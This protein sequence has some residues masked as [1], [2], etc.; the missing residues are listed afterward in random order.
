[1]PPTTR[2]SPEGLNDVGHASRLLPIDFIRGVAL[3]GILLYNIQTY[4]LFAFL[5]PEQV[6]ALS[7]DTP[8][9]YGP[10]QFLVHLF[11]KGQFYTIYSFLFGLGFY[12]IMQKTQVAGQPSA[13]LFRRRLWILL[14]L[15]L[16]HAFLFWFGD[17]LHKY[18]LLGFTLLYFNKRSIAT[19]WKWIVGLTAW[20]ILFQ[21]IKTLMSSGSEAPDPEMDKV[22]MQVVNTWQ[23][24][25]FT[26]VLSL[27]KLGV[28][29]LWIMSAMSGLSG[30]AHYEIMFLLGL[31]AGKLNLFR[32]FTTWQPRLTRWAWR[33]AP[34]AVVLKAFA[35]I[36]LLQ[37]QLLPA[38]L[39]AYE[40]LLRS[41]AEFIATPLL[42]FVYLLLLTNIANRGRSPLIRWIAQ[43]GRLG[44]TN[45]LAQTILCMLLFYGYAIGL[46]GRLSLAAALGVALL[47]Y[48]VQ[49]VYSNW[50]LKHYSMGPMETWWRRWTY[51]N[52]R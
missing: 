7:L 2:F 28:A 21:L 11:V 41:I 32:E 5:R 25:S 36:D 9:S 33:I 12:M 44:L 27:Q 24:G 31:I 15:G 39:S 6:Y 18:A 49:V 20:V 43:T 34:V 1:M 46:A 4:A 50:Y 3:A 52:A 16:I 26:A 35:C 8:G 30:F 51:R 23:H 38:A 47:I 17:I 48:I 45:Y 10:L 19:I 40:K 14:L 29:M 37:V 13:P 22:I 42:T